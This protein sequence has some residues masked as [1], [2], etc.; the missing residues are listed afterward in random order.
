MVDLAQARIAE[1]LH[2]A[3]RRNASDVHVRPGAAPSLRIDGVLHPIPGPAAD[4]A[5][6]DA[7][8]ELLLSQSARERLAES[9]DATHAYVDERYGRLRVHAFRTS[10]GTALALRLLATQVQPLE[11]LGLPAAVAG[12]ADLS[13]G[14]VLI[15]GPTG[16]GKTTALAAL[17]DR[18]NR[19][20]AKHI[21]TIEDP[22]EYRYESHR[23][24]VNQREI[25]PHTPSFS[26]AVYGALR[27]DPDVLL[28]G[29]LRDRETMH[30]AL[31]AAETGHLVL[32]TLHTGDAA[33]S[34]DRLAGSFDASLQG[35]I[36]VQLA[37]T[38]AAV[39]C[40]RLVRRAAGEGRVCAAEV[41]LGCDATRSLIRDGKSHQIKNVL[42]TQRQMGM[43]TL[44]AH[45]AELV[46]RREITA[47]AAQEAA[48]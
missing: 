30:A 40:L 35:Q 37:Q 9:G 34:I 43:Q 8:C 45:L 36:R 48:A 18:V 32:A 16:S 13:Q 42:A 39:V 31:T 23:S 11:N 33:G 17:V 21:I 24:V 20:H 47:Q 27:S 3:R 28:I 4:D 6:T 14:L 29:E 41:L 5:E 10:A 15:T 19:R 25:G 22:I 7:I 12:L 46:A 1:M 38:I 26:R 44:E 2:L